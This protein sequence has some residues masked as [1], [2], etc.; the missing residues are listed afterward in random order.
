MNRVVSYLEIQNMDSTPLLAQFIY[1]LLQRGDTFKHHLMV[2][3]KNLA[4]EP[5]IDPVSKKT[6]VLPKNAVYALTTEGNNLMAKHEGWQVFGR[7]EDLGS[8][9]SYLADHTPAGDR[10]NLMLDVIAQLNQPAVQPASD[11]SPQGMTGY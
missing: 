1:D 3:R 9:A 2:V 7:H 10:Y 6:S 4:N 11:Y 8:I 5:F